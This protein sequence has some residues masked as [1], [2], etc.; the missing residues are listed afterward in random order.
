MAG[1]NSAT[2]SAVFVL[3]GRVAWVSTLLLM[4]GTLL[5]GL[6]GARVAQIMP[7]AVARRLV[8]IVGA[9][10]TIIFAW[11]YWL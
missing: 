5:G 3:Q 8:V 4:A 6:I 11:R 1:L 7:N 2:A 10:L 9:L